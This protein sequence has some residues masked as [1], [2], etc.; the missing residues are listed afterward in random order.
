[1]NQASKHLSTVVRF[2]LGILAGFALTGVLFFTLLTLWSILG[3]PFV[4]LQS[5]SFVIVVALSASV[6]LGIW[7]YH[8]FRGWLSSPSDC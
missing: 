6:G 3:G 7:F 1:M 8:R 5:A 2:I 4:R